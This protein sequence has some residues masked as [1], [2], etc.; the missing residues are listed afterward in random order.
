M[1]ILEAKKLAEQG[2]I[3]ISPN[4]NEFSPTYFL[5]ITQFPDE[6]VFGEW[7]VKPEP[8]RLWAVYD[9]DEK[10]LYTNNSP[11]GITLIHGQRLVELVEVMK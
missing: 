6:F 4:G 7:T 1:N 10:W 2:K 8:K 9:K 11:R 3:V 5:S